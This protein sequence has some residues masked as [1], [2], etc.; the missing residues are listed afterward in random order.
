MKYKPLLTPA[1]PT[2]AESS[3]IKTSLLSLTY[4]NEV[5]VGYLN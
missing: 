5:S 1:I 2:A 3:K 4:Y